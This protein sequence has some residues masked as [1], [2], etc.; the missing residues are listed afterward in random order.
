MTWSLIKEAGIEYASLPAAR[1]DE[2]LCFPTYAARAAD[3]SYV[4]SEERGVEKLVPF[5]FECRTL[6]VDANGRTLFDSTSLGIQ[7]GF[8]CLM[9]DDQLAIV[10]RTQWE[11]LIVSPRGRVI[12]R[13]GLERLSKRIPRYATWTSRQTFLVVFFNRSHDVDIVEIDTRGRLLWY[14]PPESVSIGIVGSVQRLCS[15]RLLI[16]D[17]FRHVA[18]EVDRR[19]DVVWQWGEPENPSSDDERLSSPT[20]VWCAVEGERLIAD[21]RNH[22]ILAVAHDRQARPR[23]IATDGLC[24][25]THVERLPDGHVLVCDTGNG[26]VVEFDNSGRA[27]W[28]YGDAVAERR[29]LSYPRSVSVT[30]RGGFLIADTGNNR[31]VELIDGRI[32]EKPFRAAEPLFWPRC[33]RALAG[34]SLLIADARNGRVVLVSPEGEVR[35]QLGGSSR[36]SAHRLVDPHDVRELPNDRLL[37]CDSPQ[38][39]ILEIAWDGSV[40]QSIGGGN[41]IQ[42]KDPHS[43]QRLDDGATL[44]SDTGNHRI[45]IVGRDGDVRSIEALR[46]A[47]TL[48]RLHHPRYAEVAPDGTL[49]IADTGQ[50]RILGATL[51]GRLLWE[52]S[53]LPESR[54]PHLNQPR[55]ATMPAP[56]ELIVCDH[57]HHRIVHVRRTSAAGV[58]D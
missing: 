58:V 57:F 28:V 2:R 49:L 35:R 9:A 24:D 46:A 22:R 16:A 7:D 31:I 44:I 15:D 36:A 48:W 39:R 53:Q 27:A 32:E 25:P 42:L 20:C 3:G 4:I 45:L 43:A 34:G 11:L 19:G 1:T 18:V 33:A 41:D 50:N 12:D 8:G 23:V 52:F 54:L 55:W 5:R 37:V 51:E 21:T 13:L 29:Q 10:R 47:G 17:P 6:R 56:N 14:L 26:R 40:H 30:N 38:N